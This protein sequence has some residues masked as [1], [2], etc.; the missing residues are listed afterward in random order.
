MFI[1]TLIDGEYYKVYCDFISSKI[2]E[3]KW[4]HYSEQVK[5]YHKGEIAQPVNVK[6]FL[7][8]NREYKMLNAYNL[9]FC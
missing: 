4:E 5:K 2:S 3:D 7:R 1:K 6:G 9:C 8:I